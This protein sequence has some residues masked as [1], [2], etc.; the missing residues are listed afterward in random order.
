M[1][2]AIG[3]IV[4]DVDMAEG[5]T[6]IVME[7]LERAADQIDIP[8]GGMGIIK[9]FPAFEAIGKDN[10]IIGESPLIGMIMPA[11]EAFE[12]MSEGAEEEFREGF[13]VA[14]TL[15]PLPLHLARR[16][17]TAILQIILF[18]QRPLLGGD[19]EIGQRRDVLRLFVH[20]LRLIVMDI[21]IVIT[22][23]DARGL[24][25]VRIQSEDLPDRFI[26]SDEIDHVIRAAGQRIVDF[27]I[28][29]T[30]PRGQSFQPLGRIIP[31]E[32]VVAPAEAIG[33]VPRE[34]KIEEARRHL[35]I[36]DQVA[37]ARD[38][39]QIDRLPRRGFFR[40]EKNVVEIGFLLGEIRL[41]RPMNIG[42]LKDREIRDVVERRT[43]IFQ[44][45]F[46]RGAAQKE[47]GQDAEKEKFFLFHKSLSEGVGTVVEIENP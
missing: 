39:H 15:I 23:G 47:K 37:I 8:L 10:A 26:L 27:L 35:F 6:P 13:G 22:G 44:R 36:R 33:D 41:E 43:V 40:P 21:V 45:R 9:L 19:M 17:F 28:D 30:A 18:G 5:E 34:E 46:F 12:I 3:L 1:G 31:L 14:E 32:I 16:A 11:K 24:I 7:D 42:E 29:G 38:H 25:G 4:L 20:P 2:S